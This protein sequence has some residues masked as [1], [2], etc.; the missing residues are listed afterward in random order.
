MALAAVERSGL[1]YV[2]SARPPEGIAAMFEGRPVDAEMARRILGFAS[3][4]LFLEMAP[5]TGGTGY[6]CL[7]P[8]DMKPARK[9]SEPD[10][11]REDDPEDGDETLSPALAPVAASSD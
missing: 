6:F 1:G 9:V 5:W 7:L 4:H 2:D 11:P 3:A 10:N 8:K